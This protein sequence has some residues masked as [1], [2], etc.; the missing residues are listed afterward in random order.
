VFVLGGDDSEPPPNTTAEP[1]S[2]ASTGGGGGGGGQ[3]AATAR[4]ETVVTVLNG[5]PTEGLA[6]QSRDKLIAEGYSDEQGMIRTGNNTDQQRQDSVVLYAD[7]E[8]RQARDVGAI[9]DITALEAIDPETQALA[10]ATDA[11]NSG[12]PSKVVV[13]LGGDQSP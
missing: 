5:T 4:P 12:Q 9:L 11:T 6:S 3:A 13:I 1:T 8:R 2:E 7:G 10:D